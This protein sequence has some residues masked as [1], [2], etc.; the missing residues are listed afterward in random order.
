M[1]LEIPCRCV[2]IRTHKRSLRCRSCFPTSACFRSKY[3][4]RVSLY[5]APRR[6][7]S[8]QDR[9]GERQRHVNSTHAGPANAWPTSI[10][11]SALVTL[12]R[13]RRRRLRMSGRGSH[14]W[15]LEGYRTSEENRADQNISMGKV[16]ANARQKMRREASLR[17][18]CVGYIESTVAGIRLPKARTCRT[19][20]E[21]IANACDHVEVNPRLSLLP[22]R[23]KQSVVINHK[24][25]R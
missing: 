8:R 11:W 18:E 14:S 7:A 10:F 1:L 9:Q 5:W 23:N 22:T 24:L 3:R 16:R 12:S 25:R 21:T 17:L 13:A 20:R 6:R 15:P 4:T 2:E 19:K